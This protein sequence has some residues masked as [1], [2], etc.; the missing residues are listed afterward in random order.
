[1]YVEYTKCTA[2]G[3]GN[4]LSITRSGFDSLPLDIHMDFSASED[5][6]MRTHLSTTVEL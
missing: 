1:M 4:A 5:M 6:E 2:V 3:G